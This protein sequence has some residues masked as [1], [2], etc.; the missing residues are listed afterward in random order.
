MFL[1]LHVI[2]KKHNI[3]LLAGSI[4]VLIENSFN[5]SSSLQTD[6][7]CITF[8][9]FDERIV[10]IRS[11]SL[12]EVVIDHINDVDPTRELIIWKDEIKVWR[13]N[14]QLHRVD[15]PTIERAN[16]TREWWLN[17]KRMLQEMWEKKEKN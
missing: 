13:K 16:E 14:G 3:D 10:R 5:R 15:G 4:V 11:V 2:D 6:I 1:L 17:G 12:E 9:S 7:Q 8:M